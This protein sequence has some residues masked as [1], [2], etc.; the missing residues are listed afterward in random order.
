MLEN[1]IGNWSA[2]H[3]I[4][5]MN[6]RKRIE[7]ISREIWENNNNNEIL[8]K[9]WIKFLK[10]FNWIIRNKI[11]IEFKFVEHLR[12]I[13]KT[14]DYFLVKFELISSIEVK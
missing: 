5:Q 2:S 14:L 7:E 6:F 4:K 12:K 11:F 9:F 3:F 10:N 13:L 8:N 1:R